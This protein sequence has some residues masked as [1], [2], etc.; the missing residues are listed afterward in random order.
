MEA[1]ADGC[2][3]CIN[4]RLLE[5]R[6]LE[7]RWFDGRVIL[8]GLTARSTVAGAPDAARAMEMVR[9]TGGK[10]LILWLLQD[11]K[12]DHLKRVGENRKI[13]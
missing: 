1:S 7:G 5:G 2:V 10:G 11:G 13:Y 3:T 8:V 9:P 12:H 6:L 4:M